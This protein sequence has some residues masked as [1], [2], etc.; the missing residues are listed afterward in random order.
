MPMFLQALGD[1]QIFKVRALPPQLKLPSAEAVLWILDTL[2]VN[3]LA[4]R[5]LFLRG[6]HLLAVSHCSH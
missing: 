4:A 6:P 1:Y 5:T 3:W 2:S